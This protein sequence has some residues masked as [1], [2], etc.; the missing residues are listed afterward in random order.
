MKKLK[1]ILIGAGNRGRRYTEEAFARHDCTIAAI[2]EPNEEIRNYMRDTYHIPEN[3]C[4]GSYQ[5]VLALGKIADFALIATQD[6]MH[7]EPAM[8][9]IE[10]GYDLLLEKPAAPTPEECLTLYEAAEKKGVR[11]LICHVLRYTPFFKK[12]KE[13]IDSGKLGKIQSIIHVEGVGNIHYSHSYVRGNWGN[14]D[15]SSDMLL[16]KSCHD[17]DILQWLIGGRCTKVQSFG[18][19]S[20]FNKEHCPQGAPARCIEGCPHSDTCPYD[21]VK[22][23]RDVYYEDYSWVRAAATRKVSP[24]DA[25]IDNLLHNSN[26]GRCVFQCDNNVVDH[27]SV[28]MEFEN[29]ETVTFSMAAFN[30]GGRRIHIMGTRGELISTDMDTIELYH[31]C[32]DDPAS[33]TFGHDPIEVLKSADYVIDQAI[34]GGHGGGDGGIVDDLFKYFGEGHATKSISDIRTSVLNHLTVFAAE[35]SRKNGGILID[36]NEYVNNIQSTLS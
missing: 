8:M 17:I 26:Y 28:N 9:A 31:F 20:Y 14:S 13:I 22:I 10:L 29:G 36:V 33:E 16:A 30:K 34:T 19:L 15:T 4:F 6:K 27:Q 21:A 18:R 7:F 1:Y 24:T 3:M 25:D 2:A 23:Y 5:E 11:V 35:M 12:V 32:D